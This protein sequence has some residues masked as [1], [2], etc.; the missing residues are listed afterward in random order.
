MS[1]TSRERVGVT[2]IP[3]GF[4]DGTTIAGEL[5][6]LREMYYGP[7]RAVAQLACAEPVFAARDA[8]IGLN[9]HIQRGSAE[10]YE[11]H[12]DSS[13]LSALLYVTDHPAGSGG[14]LVVS[15]RGDVRGREEVD[16]DATRVHPVA[17]QLVVFDARHR[18]HYVAPLTDPDGVRIVV[19]M[20]YYTPSCPESARPTDLDHHLGLA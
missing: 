2:A 1:V 5:P 17:G 15:N 10:R 3:V 6:W 20:P 18:T 19:V 8:H 7:F 11:C 12:V 13:P 4:V 16:A 9:M 14:E